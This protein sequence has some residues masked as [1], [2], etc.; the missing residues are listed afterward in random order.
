MSRTPKAP[1][2]AATPEKQDGTVEASAT[3]E[4]AQSAAEQ[5][6]LE[7]E[8]E[9]LRSELESV[10]AK[11]QEYLDG[12]QRALADF[13]NF[14]RRSEREQSQIY[15]NAVAN[16]VKRYLVVVDDLERAL[17]NRPTE[18]DG[19][20]WANGIELIYRKMQ[21]ALEADDVRPIEALGKP[22]DPNQHEAIAQ[23]ASDEYSS[24]HVMDVLQ[25]GYQIGDRVVRPAIVRVAE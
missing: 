7:Q 5:A 23:E 25:Q 9:A 11:Q 22:F 8:L 3:Q 17:R 1:K 21:M 6:K 18:G 20:A 16:A 2:N 24:G 13:T 12:W 10:R 19:A 4:S 15:Q 14:K